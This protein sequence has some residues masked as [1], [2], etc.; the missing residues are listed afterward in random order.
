VA[1]PRAEAGRVV[2]SAPV[3]FLAGAEAAASV[4]PF[5]GSLDDVGV[6]GDAVPAYDE[7]NRCTAYGPW[8]PQGRLQQEL[9]CLTVAHQTCPRY[10]RGVRYGPSGPRRRAGLGRGLIVGGLAILATLTLAAAVVLAGPIILGPL[11]ALFGSAPTATPTASPSPEPTTLPTAMPTLEPTPTVEPTVEPTAEPTATTPALPTPPP[12]SPYATLAPCPDGEL[13]YLYTVR[14]GDT[15]YGIAQGFG[16]TV[17][18]IRN[19]NPAV[20]DTNTIHVGQELKIPP[21]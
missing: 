1:D 16:V 17:K 10:S 8:L 2:L 9:V 21:P 15:L 7:R 14:S 6:L 5:L 13:C 18:A 11:G 4:C 19:L 12:G 20:A 3:S